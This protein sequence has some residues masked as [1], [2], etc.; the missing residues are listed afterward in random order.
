MYDS[1]IFLN[2]LFGKLHVY[3][4]NVR[5]RVFNLYKNM[6]EVIL[7]TASDEERIIL[8]KELLPLFQHTSDYFNRIYS[9]NEQ[10][11]EEVIKLMDDLILHYTD[12]LEKYYTNNRCQR[13]FDKVMKQVNIDEIACDIG[14]HVSKYKSSKGFRQKSDTIRQLKVL[15]D[16][17]NS[18]THSFLTIRDII[19]GD[20]LNNAEL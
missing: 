19:I 17:Y 3:D 1:R 20:N 2:A 7:T 8:F 4:K 12:L 13:V 18:V 5:E 11:N 14:D 15:L 10:V 6:V 9:Q 16:D